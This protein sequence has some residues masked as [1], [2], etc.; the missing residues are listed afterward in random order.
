MS[1]DSLAPTPSESNFVRVDDL[2]RQQDDLLRQQ[3]TTGPGSVPISG[4][5]TSPT[6]IGS[7]SVTLPDGKWPPN[8]GGPGVISTSAKDLLGPAAVPPKDPKAP[9]QI[10]L[11]TTVVASA[12]GELLQTQLTGTFK[13][14]EKVNVV[15]GFRGRLTMPADESKPDVWSN[16]GSVAVNW[17]VADSKQL[18]ID[19]SAEGFAQTNTP[20][21]GG[22]TSTQIG[23]RG[24]AGMTY[25]PDP[26]LTLRAQAFV[27]A[28]R[29][30]GTAIT[31]SLIAGGEGSVGYNIG[32]GFN[33]KGTL[34]GETSN[35][36]V[37]GGT[38]RITSE[39]SLSRQF[40]KN[41]T[42]GVG[43]LHGWMGTDTLSTNHVGS[44][45]NAGFAFVN[46][47]F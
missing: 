28:S 22:P 2:L 31:N 46:V 13:V 41:V 19:L 37:G 42:A 23:I 29:T 34:R 38:G 20:L 45:R 21:N 17:R 10:S 47:R 5:T 40:G 12:Q 25:N 3:T 26:R 18:K 39:L 36:L 14:D 6:P 15:A 35:L 32:S 44:G 7:P 8:V 11:N 43:W 16:R 33:V 9:P 30:F 24:T 1:H 27:E 4:Q